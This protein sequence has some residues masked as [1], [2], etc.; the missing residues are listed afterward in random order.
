M[1]FLHWL[2]YSKTDIFKFIKTVTRSRKIRGSERRE[3]SQKNK[4]K[5]IILI[6]R[7]SNYMIIYII[8]SGALKI[9]HRWW[10]EKRVPANSAAM[11]SSYTGQRRISLSILALW[12]IV[13]KWQRSAGV[14]LISNFTHGFFD[15]KIQI[16]HARSGD[17]GLYL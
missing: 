7:Y 15:L 6:G 4:I 10:G 8:Q 17:G 11:S 9:A 12:Y 5:L 2:K 1:Y 14:M 13:D 16:K 3:R